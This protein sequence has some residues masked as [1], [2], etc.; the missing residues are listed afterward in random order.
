MSTLRLEI[1]TPESVVYTDSVDEIVLP[2]V[3]G[4]IGI[5]PHHVPLMTVL[6]AGEIRIKKG[7]E[8][9]SM[10]VS[11]GFVEVRPDAVVILADTAERAEDIDEQ[12]AE[13]ARQRAHAL[14]EEKQVDQVEFAELSSKIE[15]ELARVKVVRKRRSG[16][17]DRSA[18]S[19]PGV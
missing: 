3:Q 12:R 19:T 18:G 9:T 7:G 4:E 14:L 16:H 8:E 11:G 1:T 15:K 2:T 17:R 10:A 13:E 6:R 5:L